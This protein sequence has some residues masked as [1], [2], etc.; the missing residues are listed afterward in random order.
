MKANPGGQI[1][2]SEIIGRSEIIEQ[3]WETLAQQS[4]RLN[5]ERRIGK[6]T[7]IKKLCAE[8]KPGWVPIFQDLEQ[9]HTAFD[10]A[11]AVY[12][13]VDSFLSTRQQSARRAKDFLKAIG[14][15]EIKG[16][17]KL[18]TF[19]E[20]IPWKT[21]LTKSIED[22]VEAQQHERPLLLW[23]EMPLMLQSIATREGQSTVMEVLD[24]L[25][26]LRQEQ[27]GQ[28]LRMILT[29]SIG[30]HHVVDSLKHHGYANSP[31]NDLFAFELP[32]L[33]PIFARELATK[34]IVGENIQTEDME[35]G[36][37]AIAE[38]SDGF[39]FYIHHIVKAV[40]L[41]GREAKVD[42]INELVT[43]QLVDGNDP[44]EL[45][46]YQDRIPTYYGNNT[47][48]LV[49]SLLD[50]VAVRGKPTPVNELLQEL[51]NMGLQIDREQLLRL[52]RAVE[53]D[54]YLARD[55]QG[56]YQFKFPLLK[57]WWMLSRGL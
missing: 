9:Y 13:E 36:S 41:S 22:L 57:R 40:K 55:A 51:K 52:L 16:I 46:H 34:L 5:A 4:I 39:P 11:Q 2:L 6:T 38:L 15:T 37:I 1:D 24:T 43:K 32:T 48:S 3:I 45:A 14:G 10:F 7:I 29:G 21:L 17:L 18:P 54:H 33:T 8:P 26:A 44:W 42:S 28:G 20:Q 27:G 12:R 49:L 31:L 56:L 53:Q 25:R 19:T 47:E 30:F 50:S 23:D 35:A